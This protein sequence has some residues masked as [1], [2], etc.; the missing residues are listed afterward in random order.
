MKP[1]DAEQLSM[2]SLQAQLE[3]AQVDL[4]RAEKRIEQQL[5][6]FE[7]SVTRGQETGAAEPPP[8][9]PD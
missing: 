5:V 8:R 1:Y 6:L 9:Q 4:E 3:R 2:L 7:Q